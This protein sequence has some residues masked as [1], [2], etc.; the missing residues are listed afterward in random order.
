MAAHF[1][2]AVHGVVREGAI[3]GRDD[4]EHEGAK[5]KGDEE[6]VGRADAKGLH[7]GVEGTED[8]VCVQHLGVAQD[9]EKGHYR[10][11]ARSFEQCHAHHQHK[12]QQAALA[13][14][15]G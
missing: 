3:R 5:A 13:I 1:N 8:G 9:S 6:V 15:R 7:V 14:M 12:D 11:H 4:D 10:C 2:V